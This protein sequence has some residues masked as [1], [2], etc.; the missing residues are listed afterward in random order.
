MR[1]KQ[2]AIITGAS[3]GLGWELAD[4]LDRS[5]VDEIWVNS[6]RAERLEDL[7]R[8][9]RTPVRVIAG[10]ISGEAAIDA[11]RSAL[12]E[13]SPVVACYIYAAGF[14]KI[15]AAGR[16]PLPDLRQMIGVNDMAAVMLTEVCLPYM[17]AGSRV[18]F[19]CSV[20][21]FLPIPYLNV[22]AGT[23]AF[24]YRYGR[25]LAVE[26]APR[27]IGVTVICPYWIKDTEFIAVAR[28][29]EDQPYFKRFP[30]ASSTAFVAKAAW[31]DIQRGKAVS[32]PGW[33]ASLIHI[34]AKVLPSALVMKMSRIL[35][36]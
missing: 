3:S 27:R 2:I 16:I 35:F 19:V 28:Q 29:S 18:A 14:G 33:A 8:K 20:A 13:A 7:R 10:D 9:A 31:D 34:G 15:G 21:A 36:G 12:E 17:A 25:A 1:Q 32:T 23:K 24:L 26:L 30:L 22:Y 11:F 5:G 6:R 4:Y